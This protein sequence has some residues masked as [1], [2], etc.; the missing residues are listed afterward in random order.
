MSSAAKVLI[1]DDDPDFLEYTSIVLRSKGYQVTT[2][3]VIT[4]T[5]RQR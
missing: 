4:A 5:A 1:V 2:A 3:T